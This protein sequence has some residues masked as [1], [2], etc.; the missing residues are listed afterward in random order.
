MTQHVS[1][2][3]DAI[4]TIMRMLKVA[5]TRL[6]AAHRELNFVPA[7]IQTLRHVSQNAGSTL[8]ELANHLGVVPT[9]ASSIVDR[10][11]ARGCLSR[12]RPENDRRTIALAL[13]ATGAEAFARIEAEERAT[14]Q[15]MLDAL[16]RADRAPFVTSM[17]RIARSFSDL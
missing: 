8:S 7:D 6:H 11:V 17:T 5:E 14:M 9:T 2:L 10:L 4:T 16:P 1:D 13:T 15:L 3:H 12:V